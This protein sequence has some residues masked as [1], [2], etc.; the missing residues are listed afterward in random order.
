M[1]NDI[2]HLLYFLDEVEARE[3]VYD[4][5]TSRHANHSFLEPRIFTRKLLQGA[6]MNDEENTTMAHLW[7]CE[8]D[9]AFVV[10]NLLLLLGALLLEVLWVLS[11]CH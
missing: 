3:R 1:K 5:N 9:S 4:T 2:N 7:F 11:S 10:I 8:P 6:W